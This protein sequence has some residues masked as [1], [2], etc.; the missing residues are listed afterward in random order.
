MYKTEGER[1]K[2]RERIKFSF[3]LCSYVEDDDD[4]NDE[5]DVKIKYL[6]SR[7]F[8][9]PQYKRKFFLLLR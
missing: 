9:T 8:Y 6:P 1:K 5:W 7:F 4:N 3:F 2:E